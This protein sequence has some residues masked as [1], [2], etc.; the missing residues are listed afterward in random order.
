LKVGIAGWGIYPSLSTTWEVF[1]FPYLPKVHGIGTPHFVQKGE[2]LER[3]EDL[4]L[5]SA[6]WVVVEK[7][8]TR[9]GVKELFCLFAKVCA[10]W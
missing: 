9:G 3:E 5:G 6:S 10:A 2:R 1:C 7:Y 8:L 4:R